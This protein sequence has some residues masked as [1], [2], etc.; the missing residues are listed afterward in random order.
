MGLGLFRT[1]FCA[2]RDVID[3]IFWEWRP[4]YGLVIAAA[5]VLVMVLR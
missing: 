4:I 1:V 3:D 2:I 5:I